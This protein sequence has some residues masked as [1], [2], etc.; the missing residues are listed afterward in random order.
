MKLW[1]YATLLC[2]I[3]ALLWS[4]REPLASASTQ[5]RCVIFTETAEDGGFTVCDDDQAQFLS[6]YERWGPSQI[7]YPLSRR[8]EQEGFLMQK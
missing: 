3:L 5:A 6:A 4:W 7:G 2:L 1:R 8:Y